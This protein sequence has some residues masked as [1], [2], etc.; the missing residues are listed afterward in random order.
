[1]VN[2]STNIKGVLVAVVDTLTQTNHTD[3]EG[4]MVSV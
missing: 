2:N 4:N 1:M 3:L